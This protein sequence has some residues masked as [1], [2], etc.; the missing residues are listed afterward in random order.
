LLFSETQ[1][2]PNQGEKWSPLTFPYFLPRK[3]LNI[4]HWKYLLPEVPLDLIPLNRKEGTSKNL[5]FSILGQEM[6]KLKS[7]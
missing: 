3:S 2:Q 5:L 1:Q 6:R 4:E 7:T